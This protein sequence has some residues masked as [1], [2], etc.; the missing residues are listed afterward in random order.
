MPE[1]QRG[2]MGDRVDVLVLVR[3][4]RDQKIDNNG[5]GN[6]TGGHASNTVTFVVTYM[7]EP[8]A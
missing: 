8:M 1:P 3:D 7:T 6:L 4:V 2:D 5:S